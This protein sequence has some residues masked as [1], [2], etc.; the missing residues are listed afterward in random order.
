[1]AKGSLLSGTD[2]DSIGRGK[3]AKGGGKRSGGGG[4]S[5][6]SKDKIKIGVAAGLLLITGIIMALQ[7]GLFSSGTP[8]GYEPPPPEAIEEH[9]RVVQEMEELVEQGVIAAPA[10]Q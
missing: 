7:F 1:M 4:G 6:S 5:L 10:A 8:A 3:G 2:Y 9:R